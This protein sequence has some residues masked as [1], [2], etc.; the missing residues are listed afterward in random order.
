MPNPR[1]QGARRYSIHTRLVVPDRTTIIGAGAG[2][3]VLSVTLTAPL[4]KIDGV[5]GAPIHGLDFRNDGCNATK[6]WGEHCFF[7][8]QE[9]PAETESDCCDHCKSSLIAPGCNVQ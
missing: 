7:S 6:V 3:T 9:V 2:K 4:P 5:C 1:L 8:T